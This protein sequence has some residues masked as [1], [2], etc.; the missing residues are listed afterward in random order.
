[1][2]QAFVETGFFPSPNGI[3]ALGR[4]CRSALPLGSSKNPAVLN[5]SICNAIIGLKILIFRASGLQIPMSI[6][7]FHLNSKDDRED[8]SFN[9]ISFQLLRPTRNEG[10]HAIPP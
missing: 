9:I 5:I 4:I 1:M 10:M 7:P 2:R 8:T 6:T 3:L